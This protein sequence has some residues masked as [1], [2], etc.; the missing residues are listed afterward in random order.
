MSLNSASVV[1]LPDLTPIEVSSITVETDFDSWCWALTATLKGKDTWE[2]VKPINSLPREVLVTINGLEWKFM[3]DVPSQNRAFNSESN[4]LKGRSR[5]AWMNDPYVKNVD[6]HETQAREMVQLAE[7]AIENTGWTLDWQLENW[8]VPGGRY[9]SL[10]TPIGALIRLVNVTDDGL[11]TDPALQVMTAYKRWPVASWLIDGAT[12]DVGIPDA[13]LISLSRSP[14]YT[15]PLNGVYVS[16]INFGVLAFV[17]IAGTDGAL[18]PDAPFVDELIC[19]EAGVAA[20]QR[21][22]NI[23]S[24]AGAGFTLECETLLNDEV[25]LIIPG[26][27]I[28]VAGIKGVTRS[29][30]ISAQWQ[31]GLQVRQSIG[32][33]RREIG[34]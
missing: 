3:L 16:G 31:N 12:A 11:Y 28:E 25:G 23:L 13:A 6:R 24:K 32:L 30:R 20:R 4:S 9:N 15:T 7:K 8:V 2:L 33:E 34:E 21:G 26:K 22:L 29:V 5:S 27:I 17:K 10:N 14:V 18:Q 1:R 19:D